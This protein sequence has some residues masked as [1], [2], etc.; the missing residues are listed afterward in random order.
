MGF[1]ADNYGI[2]QTSPLATDAYHLTTMYGFWN[3]GRADNPNVSY[4]F[5]RREALEGG[6]TVV[7]GLEGV[8]DIV[9]RWQQYGFTKADIA[10]IRSQRNDDGSQKYPEEFIEYLQNLKFQLKIDAVPEGELLFP[11][12]PVMRISG[13][14]GQVKWLESV[15]LGI[16]NGHS[17]YATQ[18]ARQAD[19]VSRPLE[20]GSP[21]GAAS[22]QGMRRGPNF[23]AVFESSRSLGLGGYS[24][25][26]TGNASKMMGQPWVGTMDHAWI[27]NHPNE[28]GPIPLKE[29][30]DLH[31][32]ARGTAG[33]HTP[34]Q[35]KATLYTLQKAL[36]ND[37]FR[38]FVYSHPER[39]ILLLDTYEP[40]NGLEHAITVF[41]E[42][43]ELGMPINYGVRFDSGDIVAYSKQALRRFAEEGFVEG[44][45]P[46]RVAGM[47]DEE[48]LPWSDAC[49]LFVAAADG[50]D[51]HAAQ[52][53][54]QKGAFVRSWG[55]GT[56]GSHVAPVGF[57]YKSASISMDVP[58]DGQF[59]DGITMTPVMKVASNAPVKSSN[60]G[61]INARRYYDA[62]GKIS[63]VVLFDETLGL[64]EHEPFTNLRDFND[65]KVPEGTFSSCNILVPVFDEHGQYVYQEPEKRE[66]FPGSEHFVTDLQKLAAKVKGQLDTLTEGVR[67]I[68]RPRKE[69]IK[70]LLFGDFEAARKA[71]EKTH[72]FDIEAIMASLPPEVEHVPVYLDHNLMQQRKMVEALHSEKA[73]QGVGEYIERFAG[74][75]ETPGTTITG[76]L[77]VTG[78]SPQIQ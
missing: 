23:G 28:L 34:E 6:Y 17:G 12:E 73:E 71:G 62:E 21:Q 26:S 52:E 78:Q 39:G 44:L 69:I 29:L 3:E 14:V 60:P 5:G 66:T 2:E 37:S 35:R 33:D 49:Q 10:K 48:L 40:L 70:N 56:A 8:I 27:M 77:R 38:S 41:K 25:T 47:S 65:H 42:M 59:P 46:V 75:N 53:M 61:V 50:I 64:N 72:T 7:A 20:N 19:A 55:I 24:S 18:A 74:G 16:M 67:R 54:R 68:V 4:M 63:H 32:I 58:I 36:T 57:V 22:A 51:E 31:S 15:A 43:R 11:Q 76:D 13:P 1:I 45:D 30:F 9:K